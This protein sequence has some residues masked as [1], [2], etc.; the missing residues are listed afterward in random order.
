MSRACRRIAT[1]SVAFY[2]IINEAD[3]HI[4]GLFIS[5]LDEFDI[6]MLALRNR[7]SGNVQVIR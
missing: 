2:L 6:S 7:K 4:M 3:N 1:F 5:S